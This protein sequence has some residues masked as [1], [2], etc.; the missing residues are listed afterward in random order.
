MRTLIVLA[1]ATLLTGLAANTAAAQRPLKGT[2]SDAQTTAP[3]PGAQIHVKGTGIGTVS[4]ADG[5]FSLSVPF[6]AIALEVRRIAYRPTTIPI[7]ADQS[8][9]DIKLEADVLRLSQEIITGQATTVSRANSA[10]DVGS[11]GGAQLNETHA[12]TVDNALRGKI[13]GVEIT[14]NS[15]APGGGMQI[16]MR[17]VT[18]IFGNAEPL[19][20][21]DGLPVANTIT[22]NGINTI[23]QAGGDDQDNSV[24]R[25]ADLNPNDIESIEVLKG[26][27]AA[28]IY[29]SE[30]ANGVVVITTKRGEIGKP[31]FSLTQQFGTHALE[32]TLGLR[33]YTLA[34]AQAAYTSISPDTIAAW[35]QD[36]GGF[37][38]FEK[39]V[40]GDKS[41]SYSTNL[42][43]SG[44]SQNTQYFISGLGMHDNG[45]QYGTG[46]DKQS[47]RANLTQLV[48]DKLQIQ[49]NTNLIHTLT[50]RGISNNDNVNVSPYV[51]FSAT[52]AFFD[53]RP[54]D[55]V[56]PKNP[57]LSNSS[58]PLQTIALFQNPEDVFRFLGSVNAQYTAFTTATQ[59]LK[60]TLDL[61]IDHY[62]YNQSLYSPPTLYFEP[63]D[64]FPG[65][66]QDGNSAETRAPIAVTVAHTYTSPS[67][68]I[69]ATTSAGIRR[70]YD[71]INTVTVTT[72]DLLAGQQ[73]VNRGAN[74]A[75]VQN[76]LLVRT[77]AAYAQEDLLL[78][79]QRLFL[80]AGFLGQKSTNNAQVNKYFYYPKVAGS[81]RFQ[82]LGPFN[83]LK[84]RAAYG[85]TGNEPLYGQKFSTLAPSVIGGSNA[86]QLGTVVASADLHPE[87]ESEVEVGADAGLFNSRVALTATLYQKNNTDL[88]LQA[89]LAPS[90]G[91]T[92]RFYNAGEIRNRGGEAS[93]SI[94]P[95]QKKSLSWMTRLT[96]ARN[97]G[98][99]TSLPVP[100]FAPPG[101][102]ALAFGEG[103][104]EQ[105]KSPTQVVGTIKGV[106]TAFG[107]YEPNF[108]MG[109]SN[110]VNVGPFRF[111]GLLDW[112]DGGYAI[113]LTQ[114]LFDAGGT[115]PDPTAANARV[116]A[117]FSDGTSQYIQSTAFAKLRELTVSYRLPTEIVQSVLGKSV[118][119]ARLEFSGRNL[120]TWTHYQGLDPE[121]SNFGDQ[122]INR[123]QDVAP[124]PPSRS[125]FLTLG[126]DF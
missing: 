119:G 63:A 94:F 51:V 38:D 44:G 26:P 85:Q 54:V 106:Q 12:P 118:S 111:F 67:N 88:L 75:A 13:A 6:G 10:N 65:T 90:T 32:H 56:Y 20:I 74:V 121:V 7:A 81:Y 89:A 99:V 23:T 14:Q 102:F 98:R 70:G 120:F 124:Y 126:V 25:I 55:G 60:A 45:I 112:R 21:V 34:D 80:S 71:D 107:D 31:R 77:F 33:H 3:I 5:K 30:A 48:G 79:D 105:G 78:F 11:V 53:F 64:G 109:W 72:T 96:Y 116:N 76:R 61:S 24:N 84:L 101:S 58:N 1:W 82:N 83:E 68:S 40:Y 95:I 73:N 66:T 92:T 62:N 36:A 86:Q 49:F 17:G 57:F 117:Q 103:F 29:G 19:Y 91:F 108:I 47:V 16:R 2:V 104:I 28:A 115:S 97:V 37:H 46:Y 113:N 35:F 8:E 123:S 39:E 125:F 87:R 59:T 4:G 114:L 93:V 15:G 18:S 50:R 52:P 43:V 69:Q 9:V 41:L 22:A 100:G 110:E 27:S 42:S 122:N